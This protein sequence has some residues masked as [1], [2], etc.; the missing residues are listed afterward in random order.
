MTF[1]AAAILYIE[2]NDAALHHLPF[3]HLI[4]KAGTKAATKSQRRKAQA[5]VG[6]TQCKNRWIERRKKC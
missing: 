1:R 2:R 4:G 6:P 3:V 5:V